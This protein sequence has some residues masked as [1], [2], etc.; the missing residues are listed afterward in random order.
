MLLLEQNDEWLVQRRYVSEH[1]MRLIISG[2]VQTEPSSET[3][4]EVIEEQLSNV[5]GEQ[6]KRQAATFSSVVV[7]SS[8]VTRMPS[9]KFMPART[10]VTSSWPLSRRQRSWAASKSL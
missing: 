10:S 3:E 4:K 5:V 1:S 8:S 2:A 6:V 7:V 9:L